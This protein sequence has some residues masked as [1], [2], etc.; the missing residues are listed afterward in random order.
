MYI[1]CYVY[2][3][4]KLLNLREKI[5]IGSAKRK[6]YTCTCMYV[7]VFIFLTADEWCVHDW[8]PDQ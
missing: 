8:L 4:E 3:L 2:L 5:R 1:L 7:H 6:K